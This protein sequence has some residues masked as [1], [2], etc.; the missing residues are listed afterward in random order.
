MDSGSNSLQ[1][2]PFDILAVLLK[3]LLPPGFAAFLHIPESMIAKVDL[4][5]ADA[6]VYA[7]C[8]DLIRMAGDFEANF[9]ALTHVANNGYFLTKVG[10]FILSIMYGRHTSISGLEALVDMHKSPHYRFQIGNVV[11]SIEL[12]FSSISPSAVVAEVPNEIGCPFH[13]MLDD[14][15]FVDNRLES[16][17]CFFQ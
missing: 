11:S 7:R 1:A 15:P 2:M 12:V 3:L 8:R 17:M 13:A 6:I 4:G 10:H 9:V 5:V 14:Q 16:G